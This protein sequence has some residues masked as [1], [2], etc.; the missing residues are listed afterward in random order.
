MP[1]LVCFLGSQYGEDFARTEKEGEETAREL[2]I[3]RQRGKGRK[4]V[5]N[6][7]RASCGGGGP[8]IPVRAVSAWRGTID[9]DRPLTPPPVATHWP[10]RRARMTGGAGARG[11]RAPRGGGRG[12]R[13]GP[14]RGTRRADD[15][16]GPAPRARGRG[17][18]AGSGR[19]KNRGAR[20]KPRG[21]GRRGEGV[22]C[23]ADACVVGLWTGMAR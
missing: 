23:D 16:G 7:G 1:R 10:L 19:R 2:L 17:A 5:R 6:G 18:L 13:A 3:G 21:G 20:G 11:A 15:R 4:R 9:S 22:V 14:S 12:S 8:L